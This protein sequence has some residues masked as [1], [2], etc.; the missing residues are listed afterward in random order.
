M[1]AK[2]ARRST[3]LQK[4]LLAGLAC[5]LV[6]T[7]AP[8]TPAEADPEPEPEPLP[9]YVGWERFGHT[10]VNPNVAGN[11]TRLLNIPI[12]PGRA[13][14]ATTAN[15]RLRV[16]PVTNG[17]S[18]IIVRTS[19]IKLD[20]G[21]S[22]YFVMHLHG[23][24]SLNDSSFPGPADG[25]TF[26]IQN[27]PAPVLG[28]VGEGVGYAGIPN[29]VGVE[30]DTW[31]NIGPMFAGY[32]ADPDQAY[33]R[34]TPYHPDNN[35]NG[36]T[37]DHVAIVMNGDNTHAD[38]NND[39]VDNLQG[40]NFRLYDYGE[41]GAQ[42]HVWVDYAEDGT[43]TTTY[44]PSA[45]RS[46]SNNRELT[47][48]VGTSLL[49]QE[50]YVGFGASTGG[51]NSHHDILAWYFKDSYVDGGLNPAGDYKQG[52][53]TIVIDKTVAEDG[54]QTGVS[55]NVNGYNADDHLPGETVEIS[56]NGQPLPGDYRTNEQGELVYTFDEDSELQ[57]GNNTITVTSNSWG[58]NSTITVVKTAAPSEDEDS[59]TYTTDGA[60][61]VDGV[62][63]GVIF[64][65]YDDNGEVIGKSAPAVNGKAHIQLADE[66]KDKVTKDNTVEISYSKP[67]E[68]T[69]DTETFT[70]AI[71]NSAPKA[72][73]IITNA[74]D[75][76]VTVKDV[77][78]GGKVT[79]YNKDGDVIGEETNDEDA[80]ADVTVT[81]DA[82]PG[83]N[84]DDIV[85]VTIK[86]SDKRESE[87]AQDTAKLVSDS[88]D[89]EEVVT[90][91]TDNTVTVKDVP[92]GTTVNVYDDNG[93]L[94]GTAT[95]G[96]P[97]REVV[98]D[99][100]QPRKLAAHE[101]VKVT[102]TEPGELESEP[103]SGEAKEGSLLD[104]DD[105]FTNSEDE[106][107]TVKDVPPGATITVYDDNGD[108]IG[109][110]TN[111]ADATGTVVVTIEAP[112]TLEEGD[113][114]EVTITEMDKLESKPVT[115][116]AKVP[117]D[118]LGEADV[119]SN[120]TRDT[121]TVKDVPPGSTVNIYDGNGE[122]IGTGTG[123]ELP[124]ETVVVT[125]PAPPGLAAGEEV[126]VTIT[127]PGKLESEPVSSEAKLESEPPADETVE[128]RISTGTVTAQDV[129]PGATVIVYDEEGNELTRDENA[130]DQPGTVVIDGLELEPGTKLHVTIIEKDKL[131][132][133][134]VVI[135][136]EL[137]ADEAVDDALKNLQI[138]YQANDTWESV[139]LP[140]L[141]VKIGAN[142]TNVEW[143]SSKPDA[144]E[145]A[146]PDD[147]TVTTLVHRAEK[148]ES[149]I[150]TATVS[151]NGVSKSRTFLLIVKSENLTKTTTENVRQV[152]VTGG[153][154]EDE[155]SEDVRIDR[156][157]LYNGIN[158]DIKIDKAIF[159]PAAAARFIADAR[160]RDGV[161]TI[162]VDEVAGDEADEIAVEIPGQ[163]VDLLNGNGNSL[164]IRTDYAT[165]TITNG[166]LGEMAS[167]YLDL[168]FRLIP[169][170][171][172]ARQ[173]DLNTGILNEAAVKSAAAGRQAEVVGSSL[174]IETNYRDFATT[175]FL[176]FA[177]NGITLPASN[178]NSFVSSLR[179]FIE[180]SDGEKVVATPTV[181][182]EG[183][184]PIGL[185]I[186]IDK[187][188]VFSVIRLKDYPYSGITLPPADPDEEQ[189]SSG[190]LDP[191][192]ETLVLELTEG[193]SRGG[194]DKSGFTVKIGD[195]T[196]SIE[197]VKVEGDKV[198][199][200]LKD[201]VP[202]GYMAIVSYTPGSGWSSGALRAFSD[203]VIAN[204]DHHTAYI[205]GF[206]DGTFRPDKAITRAEMSAILARN[207]GLSD[208]AAYQGLYPDA[209][210]GYWATAYIEQ[211][212][213]IG[214][215]I[216]D[217]QGNFRPGH[218]ITRAEIAMV[219]ARWLNA[220][221]EAAFTST[222][223][224]VPDG[225][226]AAAAI[227]A[228]SEAGIMIGFEDGSFG[229]NSYVTRAQAV[230]IMNRLLG[231]GPLTGVPTPTWPDAAPA[232]WASQHIEEASQD[233]DFT[234]LPEGGEL[235]YQ[236]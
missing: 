185:A 225:H 128:A 86:E 177:K 124:N 22:T 211:L 65:L 172:A 4:L 7:A 54:E 48:D 190:G 137:T 100:I 117:G 19:K 175:L 206:P 138:G 26:I 101:V 116:E 130:G 56:V 142:G 161:S 145:I 149:V 5:L 90:N 233:H 191:S 208:V 36:T 180:H 223:E 87:K 51:A 43:L 82:P 207:K 114:V 105:V 165:L 154:D 25:M 220:D 75:D 72:G 74:T 174:E 107:V 84:K 222:F 157:L 131:E 81:I 76:T 8:V 98:V 173:E 164:N 44:G 169:V 136:V 148:D 121:V 21:F 132:S 115:S 71:R 62:P 195:K 210:D 160:T 193:S 17:S 68:V 229:M 78:P 234:F 13:N 168:F 57:T 59:I 139:T 200:K 152:K 183:D 30:F 108:V 134:I 199:L 194:I 167:S 63:D 219:A 73:D 171:D 14:S 12:I 143:T 226:W 104:A 213:E 67:G 196:A 49:N 150:M 123:T 146:S 158:N 215:L 9:I 97:S 159:D 94:I 89:E 221:L 224:D 181:V 156:V 135:D 85:L 179:V 141:I 29:S 188:S 40:A 27:N 202:A 93:E 41:L 231:R 129:P 28:M 216:G 133:E 16:V 39:P 153:P 197:E 209:A 227:A 228:A 99:I 47:R 186:D 58:T 111:E 122:L 15:G 96:G 235:L 11:N 120:A 126:E 192:G 35:P 64:T 182:Y 79:I 33:N 144:I 32:Y 184:T 83:L 155:V 127:R 46:D 170:K 95:N 3:L 34:F 218:L 31:K 201:P 1:Q 66:D 2:H 61:T 112:H 80:P 140:V 69:S 189:V 20:G 45:T 110:V 125:I 232:H 119:V 230:T 217:D 88:P 106:T 204:P 52:P 187:F 91:A 18:G 24:T 77:P 178:V 203:L 212:Q 103:T 102:V 205:K 53:S 60:V 162:Y 50:V 10:G 198:T 70:P 163:S 151:K 214:L 38:G 55:V 92:P 166:V 109:T 42:V 113:H 23:S 147:D 37:A 236:E 6:L 118:P 176:A